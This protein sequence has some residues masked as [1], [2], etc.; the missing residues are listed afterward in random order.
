M[1]L[2]TILFSARLRLAM[3]GA[4][5][6]LILPPSAMAPAFGQSSIR[7]LVNDEPI[8]SFD[9]QHRAKMM[10]LF[11]RGQQGEK[12]AIEQLIDERLM[13]QEAA[14]RNVEVADAEVD[15]EFARRAGQAKLNPSQ[16]GQALRQSGIDPQTFRDFLHANLAWAEIVRARFRATVEVTDQDVTA[17]LT[18]ETAT[19]EQQTTFE[20][21]LQ[22]IVFVVPASAGAGVEAQ[23]RNEAT[24]FRSAFQGCEASLQQA[25]GMPGVV[26]KPT[27]RREESQLSDAVKETL[28]A[29]GIGGITGPERM[30]QG[31]QLV[32]VC[33]KNPIAGQTQAAAEVR[34]EISDERGRLLARRY[35]RDLRSDAVIE[36]R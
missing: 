8:T 30:D 34:D 11:S 17:A 27:V 16:F 29:A 14:R 31:F 18:D 35:L 36:Y 20:Y 25:N 1:P 32:A 2:L 28:A 10:S 15:Q 6:A 9:I 3:L 5:L 13:L 23:R 21:M 22:Q 26:V 7:I 4:L 12:D 24:A 33:A 19:G